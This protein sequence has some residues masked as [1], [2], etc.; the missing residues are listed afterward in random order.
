V[1]G[2][3]LSVV[4]CLRAGTRVDLAW[5]V[6][7][8]GLLPADRADALA[9][10]PGGGR[11]GSLLS[12]AADDQLSDQA[13][14]GSRRGR[15]LDVEVSD[16][17][18]LVAG[19]PSGGRARC[20]LIPATELPAELWEVL[21]ARQPV[22]L[23]SALDGDEVVETT[24]ATAETIAAAG[25]DVAERFARGQSATV[26]SAERVVTILWPV[27][28]L[29]IVGFGPV[30]DALAPAAALLGWRT[31]T[32]SDPATAAGLIAALAGLDKLVVASHDQELAGRALAAALDSDV[33]YIGALGGRRAQQARAD[34]L[35][36]RGYSDLSRIH[37]P[38]GLDI[39]A[40]SPAE[41]A[42]SILAEAVAV[43]AGTVARA[44][45]EP[46]GSG[47]R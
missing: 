6:D 2:I 13:A 41:I 42:V 44:G 43:Q 15:L 5:V 29:V 28:Q 16:V 14:R 20:L 38:A 39:G 32:V 35:A 8:E 37:G 26:V 40:D 22:A 27:P 34:W 46:T 18:A 4:A 30:A 33:G 24:L 10:T 36:Y 12:G 25:E 7:T 9:I 1:Y 31:R 17:D 47:P 21:A 45:A 3:T 11:V 19:L 23:I